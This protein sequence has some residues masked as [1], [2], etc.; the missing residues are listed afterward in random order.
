M[1][2]FKSDTCKKMK[3]NIGVTGIDPA[4]LISKFTLV[5]ENV[6]VSFPA[7]MIKNDIVVEI[8]ALENAVGMFE[9]NISA[10]LEVIAGDTYI[11]PWED[12]VK[13]DKVV[14]VEATITEVEEIEK[15][16]KPAIKA[17]IIAELDKEPEIKVVNEK[18]KI[19]KKVEKEVPKWLK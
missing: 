12:T 18:K 3:F 16:I 7:K 5:S 6:S 11:T 1:I 15:K 13:I 14:K 9:G 10:K 4:A 2:T 8:P 17:S 19:T